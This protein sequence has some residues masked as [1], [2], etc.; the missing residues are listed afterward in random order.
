MHGGGETEIEFHFWRAG[1]M[2]KVTRTFEGV[3]PNLERLYAESESEFTKNRLKGFMNPQPCDACGG[4]RLKPEILAVTLQSAPGVSPGNG[5]PKLN[6]AE[7]GKMPG[8]R[9]VP[10]FSI[11]D[12]CGMSVERADQFFAELSRDAH[13][14]PAQDRGRGHQGDSRATRVPEK[15]WSRLPHARSRKRHAERRRGAAHSARDANRRRAGR[16]ALHPRRAEHRLHQ[17]DN[18]RLLVTLEGLREFG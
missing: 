18:E 1:K 6:A 2:S 8:A 16:R 7:P 15:C 4:Q 10:G 14:L 9:S 12:V 11:M 13:G 5:S 17:R 3:I